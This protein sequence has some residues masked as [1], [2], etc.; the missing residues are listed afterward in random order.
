M[1]APRPAKPKGALPRG[2]E[3]VL[4]VEEPKSVAGT[5]A[6][7]LSELGYTVLRADGP[8]DAIDISGR[9]PNGIQLLVSGLVTHGMAGDVLLGMLKASQP[10]L[11]VLFVTNGADRPAMAEN[12]PPSAVDF[13]PKPFSRKALAFKVREVLDR[14]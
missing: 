9:Q 10:N 1:E 3:T 14:H 8:L 6:T 13:L 4:L 11:R 5:A 7:V 12:A 2:T